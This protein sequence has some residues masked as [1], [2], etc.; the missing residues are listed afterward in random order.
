MKKLK[1][2]TVACACSCLFM[3]KGE[4]IFVYDDDW[5][6]TPLTDVTKIAF[7][8][9]GLTVYG[10]TETRI[11]LADFSFF[12]FSEKEPPATVIDGAVAGNAIQAWLDGGNLLTVKAES[13]LARVEIYSANGSLV[14]DAAPAANLYECSLENCPAGMYLVKA[15]VGETQEL[16]KIVKR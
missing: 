3:A 12:S 9:E 1:L 16:H 4:D 15:T 11:A 8:E 10:D 5:K 13:D 2:L 14:T 7:T 6:V